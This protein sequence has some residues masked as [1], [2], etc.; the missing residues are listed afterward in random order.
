MNARVLGILCGACLFTSAGAQ[1]IESAEIRDAMVANAAQLLATVARGPGPIEQMGGFDRRAS[2]VFGAD[3]AE[4]QNWQ[5]WPAA[6]V[7]LPLGL[8]TAEQRRLT[9]ALL[10]AV[11]SSQGYL[12]AIQI[13]HLDEILA[14]TDEAG[15]PRA[16]GHYALA[17]FGEPAADHDWGWRF[18]GHHVSLNIAVSPNRITV[19]PSF[20]GSNPAEVE[21]GPLTGL[22]VHGIVEDLARELV[23]SLDAGERSRAIISARAPGE[24]LTTQLR[25]ARD[26]WA[27]WIEAVQPEGL[28]VSALNEVQQYWVR[29][30]LAEVIGNYRDELARQVR[31]QIDVETLSFAW[32]GSI[33][34]GAPHYFRLQGDDF[35]FEYDNVQNDG[36][37]VHSVWRSKSSDFGADVLLSHYRT[38]AHG[39]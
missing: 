27:D 10:T 20:F 24:I 4:R 15:F 3:N 31:D 35:A 38:A 25:V 30:I 19:T 21:T 32:M 5:Y 1:P 7:G 17:I 37:H 6:R 22:R 34:R 2:M 9:Q 13:Q 26:R 12:K 11:L 29:R 36:N 28:P 14:E 18:E 8:M 33:E 16:L 39:N 23:T